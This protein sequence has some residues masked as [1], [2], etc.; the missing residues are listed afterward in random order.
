V[1][2]VAGRSGGIPA[3]VRDGET[4]LL[5]DAERADDVAGAVARLLDDG[6]LRARLGAAGRRAVETHYNWDR[7]TRDLVRLGHELGARA[8]QAAG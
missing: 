8:A 5:V 4:G 7:V 1:P 6:E 2:V 3:A